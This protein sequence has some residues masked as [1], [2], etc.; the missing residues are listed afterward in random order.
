MAKA[1][2]SK[3][4]NRPMAGWGEIVKQKY[5]DF[6]EAHLKWIK[7]GRKIDSVEYEERKEKNRIYKGAIRYC[8]KNETEFKIKKFLKVNRKV[9]AVK[10]WGEVNKIRK[11][12]KIEFD[13]IDGETDRTKIAELWRKKFENIGI[14]KE[15]SDNRNNLFTDDFHEKNSCERYDSIKGGDVIEALKKLEVGKARGPDGL[16]A[17]QIKWGGTVLWEWVKNLLI[18][19]FAHAVVFDANK[20]SLVK[21]LIKDKKGNVEN[22][23]NYRGISIGSIWSKI[24]DRLIL[25]IINGK[26]D[27][28]DH[29]FGFKK[30]LSTKLA[31]QVLIE[32]RKH[33]V[34]KGG[35]LFC[36]FIDLK[37]AFDKLS[38]D[39]I[40]QKLN[41]INIGVNVVNMIK[42]QYIEQRR[43]VYWE[44][45][46]SEDFSVSKG[47]K[48]GSSLSPVLF[49]MVL[50]EVIEEIQKLRFGCWIKNVN[51]NILLYADDIV[52]LGPSRHAVEK[53]S[54]CLMENL[55]QKGLEINMNKTVAMEMKED[56]A[57][58]QG[59]K[60]CIG[61]NGIEWVKEFKFLGVVL[62][63]D[64]KW[65]K[66]LKEVHRKMN[67]SGNI[68]LHQFGKII[69]EEELFGLLDSCAF[70]LY[71]IEF[72]RNVGKKIWKEIEMSYHWLIKRALGCS[73][74]YSNHL[75]CAESRMLTWELLVSWKKALLWNSIRDNENK[76]VYT[77]FGRTKW[78]SDL[79]LEMR[80]FLMNYGKDCVKTKELKV[81]LKLYIEAMAVLKGETEEE[82]EE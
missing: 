48:Q 38:Y 67:K 65:D 41:K 63:N 78:Y 31:V 60:I 58:G 56:G 71:G 6:K 8:K 45:V 55:E 11:G 24:V 52:I 74:R 30:G 42:T 40:W 66:H 27:Q 64:C 50:D 2:R 16:V 5:K 3:S 37:K 79:G 28:N 33:F 46:E 47:V 81:N 61:G 4:R 7:G 62:Q 14:G 19:A 54:R 20:I 10:F 57:F 76:L 73:K 15:N 70:D 18:A 35:R 80:A 29:Q 69:K 44:G 13:C 53:I 17:E 36:V 51:Y 75:A 72:C 68:I 82:R 49:T 9:N 22:S 23:D 1:K 77:L 25:K 43:K 12:G 32:V 21:P 26:L 59:R 39:A 34:R